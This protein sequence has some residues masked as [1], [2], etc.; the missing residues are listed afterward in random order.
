MLYKLV[1]YLICPLFFVAAVVLSVIA[2]FQKKR[3]DYPQGEEGRPL[4]RSSYYDDYDYVYEFFL[5]NRTLTS[6]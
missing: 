3:D 6:N 4:D 1:D 5:R 2:I